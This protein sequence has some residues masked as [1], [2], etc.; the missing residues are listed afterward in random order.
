MRGDRE[1]P[2]EANAFATVSVSD[3]PVAVNAH[4]QPKEVYKWSSLDKAGARLRLATSVA[5]RMENLTLWVF[6]R[7]GLLVFTQYRSL[8]HRESACVPDRDSVCHAVDGKIGS[9]TRF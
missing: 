4:V 8:T 7:L 9:T 3:D 5:L 2:G 6:L 1:W